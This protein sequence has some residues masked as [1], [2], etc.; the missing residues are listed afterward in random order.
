MESNGR[1]SAAYL[2]VINAFGVSDRDC[3]RA[4]QFAILSMHTLL[5]LFEMLYERGRGDLWYYDENANFVEFHFRRPRLRQGC[6][7]GAFPFC[8][9]MY[10]V[11][12]RL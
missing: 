8:L 1:L 10:C 5:P 3:I 6:V 9:A 2:D 12:A 4:T 11:Y 7:I